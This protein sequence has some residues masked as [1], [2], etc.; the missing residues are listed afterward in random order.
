MPRISVNFMEVLL[1]EFL[2]DKTVYIDDNGTEVAVIVKELNYLPDL[3]TLQIC[4]NADPDH[5][6][7]KTYKLSIKDKFDIDY[8]EEVKKVKTQ[9]KIK[10]KR[11]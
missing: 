3:T 11:T 1:R 5:P 9:K 2:I 6:S 4:D 10:G 8:I 7:A